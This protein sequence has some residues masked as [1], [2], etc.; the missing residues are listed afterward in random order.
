MENT[1]NNENKKRENNDNENSDQVNETKSVKQL[2]KNRNFTS[3][4][5][6][7]LI[8][9]IGSQ[10]TFI[11][12]L[13]LA[14]EFTQD[15][16]NT[17]VTQMIA[18]ISIMFIIPSIVL[19]PFAGAIADRFDRKKIMVGAEMFNALASLFLILMMKYYRVMIGIYIF[20][21]FMVVG[22][23][24]FNP[25][26]NGAFP[27]IVAKD[28]LVRANSLRSTFS[29]LSRMIGPALAGV[30]IATLGLQAAFILDTISYVISGV[31]ILSINVELNPDREE[32]IKINA[33]RILQ[34][35]GEGARLVKND[36]VVSFIIAI[37]A[38]AFFVI[39]ITD[40]ILPAYLLIDLEFSETELG[41]FFSIGSVA[42]VVTAMLFTKK[43]DLRHKLTITT[44]SLLMISI[45]VLF[46]GVA[47][48]TKFPLPFLLAGV[49]IGGGFLVVISVPSSSLLQSIV[50]NK[51][52][53]KVSG[54]MNSALSMIQLLAAIMVTVVVRLVPIS[55]IFVITA[56][57]VIFVTLG[58]LGYIKKHGLEQVSQTR[59]F[60]EEKGV[61][62]NKVALKNKENI[63]N[64]EDNPP[65][66]EII[67]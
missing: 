65:V 17:Q 28:D 57:L 37:Y 56:V 58:L 67:I 46:Y 39:G 25:A 40:P 12:V 61:T 38:L 19:S 3:L 9:D 4:F 34:D 31:L 13:F 63:E 5:V 59:D 29:E 26:R 41:I 35:I 2:L 22:R 20:S 51:D 14:I 23:V 50:D 64:I 8:S 32:T 45:P 49:I 53:G 16:D 48:L 6:G 21:F 24:I 30:V 55:T 52:L 1:N 18:I 11:A 44:V 60:N 10:F 43:G 54:F 7:G 27:K 62:E 33:R 47:I 42:G 15:L 36:R 66:Q